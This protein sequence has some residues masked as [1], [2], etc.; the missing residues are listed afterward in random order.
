[1]NRLDRWI[2]GIHKMCPTCKKMQQGVVVILND[3]TSG[4]TVSVHIECCHCGTKMTDVLTTSKET[5][6]GELNV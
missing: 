4:E 3:D 2:Q 5:K 1:M 6:Q